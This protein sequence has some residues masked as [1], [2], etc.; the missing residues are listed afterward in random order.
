[1]QLDQAQQ[2]LIIRVTEAYF[3][4]L[5]AV[6]DLQFAQSEKTA[7]ARQLEQ[8][9]KRFEVGLIPVTDVKEAQSSYDRAVAREIEAQTGVT[10]AQDALSTITSLPAEPLRT[11]GDRMQLLTP[12]PND[13]DEWVLTAMEQNL[14]LLIAEYDTKI[15]QQQIE[16][17][18][19]RHLPTLDIVASHSDYDTGGI[20]GPYESEDSKIGIELNIPIFEGGRAYYRTTEARHQHRASLHE[21]EQIRRETRQFTRDA[22]FK[23]VAGISRVNAFARSVESAE[24]AA[25]SSEAGFQVGTRTSVDVLIALRNVYEAKRDYARSRY[26]YLLDSLRL[27]QAAGILQSEDLQQ[28]ETWL[29]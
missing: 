19:A 17:Q 24:V 6:D 22:F 15:A 21:Q 16:L 13:A 5:A 10:L 7:I 9:E 14:A 12:E 20:S 4:V 27:K 29:E 2:E 11:V 3:N 26:D 8:A 25:E 18:R 1:V 28:I 23:M